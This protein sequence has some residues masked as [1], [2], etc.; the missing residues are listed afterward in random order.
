MKGR[1]NTRSTESRRTNALREKYRTARW[2]ALRKAVLVRDNYLCVHCMIRGK[3]E[4]GNEIDH[5]KPAQQAPE[6][7]FEQS[8]LQ[9]LCGRCHAQ[10]TRAGL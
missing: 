7:F 3:I 4:V 9:T 8:N 5:I 10:K 6:L 1:P 2:R